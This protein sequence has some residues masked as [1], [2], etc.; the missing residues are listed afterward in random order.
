VRPPRALIWQGL[1]VLGA[2]IFCAYLG[3]WQLRRL[4]WK[5]GLIAAVEARAHAELKPIPS[6]GLWADLKSDDY[7]YLHVRAKGRFDLAHVALVFS[8]APEGG[9]G[10]EPGFSA[11][12][13]L[14][15]DTGGV[16]I[17]NR[18]FTPQSR[19]SAGAWRVEP[20]GGTTVAGWLH[21]P[22]Q[23]NFFTP[24]DDPA[25]EK[26]FTADPA[27]IGAAFGLDDVAPFVL[28]EEATGAAPD[29]LSR[30]GA[31]DAAQIP[32]NHFGYAITWFGL[33]LVLTLLFAVYA[34]SRLT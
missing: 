34:K 32:N 14:L 23:R 12:T 17:V 1:F 9:I 28:E 22:Q 21:A 3:F 29:G 19:A 13:P 4:A 18:G 7:A 6:R 20:S 8:P 11:L 26:W 24:D 27:T 15:L 5:E 10:V 25:H 16:V 33:A 30:A 31:V 2:A